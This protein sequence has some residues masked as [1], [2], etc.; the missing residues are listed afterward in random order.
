MF[1]MELLSNVSNL[2]PAGEHMYSSEVLYIFLIS[3]EHDMRI[4]SWR[5]SIERQL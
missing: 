3:Y 2:T 4:K 5:H 1:Q